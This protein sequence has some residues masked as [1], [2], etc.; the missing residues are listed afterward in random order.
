[1]IC[2]FFP[3]L[4]V[5]AFAAADRR[6][7][8]A[9]PVLEGISAPQGIAAAPQSSPFVTGAGGQITHLLNIKTAGV[10]AKTG[11]ILE[12]ITSDRAGDLY[13]ADVSRKAVLKVTQWGTISVFANSCGG[14]PIGHPARVTVGGD[15]AIYFTDAAA[16]HLCRADR[17]G[18]AGVVASGFEKPAGL[19]SDVAMDRFLIGAADGAIWTLGASG[20][21]VR[22]AKLTGPGKPGGMAL[23]ESG[24]L[25]IARNGG[26][27]VTVLDKTGALVTELPVPGP[28]VSDVAFAGSTL[29]DLYVTEAR[30]GSV[31]RLE[32]GRRA[33]RMPWEA[34]PPLAI[35]DP[36]DGAILN[37]HDGQTT[38]QGLRVTVAGY[39]RIA[40]PVTVNGISTPVRNGRFKTDVVLRG[41]E[42]VILA[43][44]G[45][46]TAA[47]TVLWD[48]GSF[49]RY[50]VSTDD[51]IWFLRDIARHAGNYRSIFENPYLAFWRQMHEK[52]GTK[53]HFNI[54]YETE[55]FN[56]SQMPDK[57][58][59][60]WQLNSDW[61]RLTCH[62]RANDPDRPY[63]HASA[64]QMGEDFRLV[65]R[66]I[67][68]FAG[69]Q[70]LSPVTTVHWGVF[71][72][73]GARVLHD[74][75]IRG[76]V[77]YFNSVNNL[78]D[79]C[80]YLP[81]AQ[82][83]YLMTHDYWKDTRE[84]LILIRHD[85]VINLFPVNQIIPRLEQIASD[86]HQSE[87]MELMIHEQYFYPDYVAYEPDY[88]KRVETALEW[89]TNHGYKPV[90]Y[91][92][93]FLGVPE[94]K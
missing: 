37:R 47:A 23:D 72:R 71:P 56:L 63:V 59:A 57:Y 48:R 87:I 36:V 11:D 50:R 85:M 65:A 31:Y 16:G 15:T 3:T 30:T 89:V 62:A 64:A 60:E 46:S 69:K 70:L 8:R 34:D 68:R 17:H 12:G 76:T 4:A 83:R 13:V 78:P 39:S 1:M 20:S 2:V 67:E 21:P 88:R 61:M 74:L 45:N 51:N 28:D 26:G 79:V 44:A 80:L 90:L 32:I 41:R 93:G 10:L 42:N 22:F 7:P 6:E 58:R 14:E 55:G 19:V 77:A 38:P 84:D 91:H 66:E 52:Y 86:P 82:W 27:R 92:E 75:G 49:R 9:V 33:Q 81:L 43:K 29:S 94:S 5:F 54:Y 18:G 40:G 25:Y 53:V 35:T 73:P 24:N